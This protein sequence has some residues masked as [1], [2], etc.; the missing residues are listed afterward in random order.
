MSKNKDCLEMYMLYP[1]KHQKKDL[2]NRQYTKRKD[3]PAAQHEQM[4]IEN[5]I[6]G[7]KNKFKAS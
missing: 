3:D 4:M 2:V 6:S 5:A 7:A 1:H